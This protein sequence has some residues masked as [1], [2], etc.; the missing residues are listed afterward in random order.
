MFEY[1]KVSQNQHGGTEFQRL[2]DPVLATVVLQK[3]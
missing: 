3:I 2:K 1:G